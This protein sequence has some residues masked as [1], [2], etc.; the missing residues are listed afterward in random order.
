MGLRP[1]AFALLLAAAT[2]A[3]GCSSTNPGANGLPPPPDPETAR[4]QDAE[5]AATYAKAAA[6]MEKEEWDDARGLFKD[7]YEDYPGSPLAPEAQY[8]AAECAYRDGRLNGAGELFAKYAE[9]RP[10]SLHVEAVEKRLYDIGIRLIEDGKRGLWGLGIF[11]SSEEGVNVL[12]RLAT[13]LPTGSY[14]DDALLQI[15][16]WYAGDRQFLSAEMTLDEL[17]KDHPASEW[18]LEAHYLLAW[19][20]RTDNRGPEYDGEKLR[21][22]RAEFSAFIHLA[23]SDPDR[24][25]DNAD[26]IPKAKGELDAIDADLARKAL[27]R[28]RLYRRT[29]KDEAALTVLREASRQWGS[30]EP[31]QECAKRAEA[32][33]AELGL[34]AAP[35]PAPA[36]A[37]APQ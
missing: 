31:G 29:G 15:A 12:R 20:Y 2:A 26:R 28:A 21:R 3:A 23:S 25:L 8:L 7:V 27:L 1:L 22:A 24:A 14:A 11:T 19:T 6:L 13:L 35:A 33:A 10:L 5:A 36:P 32:L 37:E 30:T 34:P 16:R 9:D 18:V 17:L 4:K